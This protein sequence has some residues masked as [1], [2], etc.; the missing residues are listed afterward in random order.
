MLFRSGLPRKAKSQFC[1]LVLLFE[2]RLR[3]IKWLVPQPCWLGEITL[4]FF[5]LQKGY[6]RKLYFTVIVKSS[7]DSATVM[8][9]F[10]VSLNKYL[11]ILPMMPENQ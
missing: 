3:L 11:D 8:D 9:E 7:K 5:R 2:V 1:M 4:L 6:K 10:I